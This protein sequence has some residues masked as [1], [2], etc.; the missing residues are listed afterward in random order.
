M[1]N[2]QVFIDRAR[3]LQKP[4]PSE[5]DIESALSNYNEEVITQSFQNKIKVIIW[6]GTSNINAA[7]PDY[8]KEENPW[9]D[10]AYLI[11]IDNQITYFQTHEP[12]VVGIVPLTADSISEVSNNHA[13]IIAVELAKNQIIQAVMKDLGLE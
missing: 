1:I 3:Y 5:I 10:K 2:K 8:I 12:F 11:L 13:S 6:D 9:I 4:V 7:S